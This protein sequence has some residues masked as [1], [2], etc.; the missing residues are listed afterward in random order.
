MTEPTRQELLAE[1]YKRGILPDDM[2]SN[3]EEAMRRGLVPGGD[4]KF[5]VGGVNTPSLNDM[6]DMRNVAQDRQ[7]THFER[8]LADRGSKRRKHLESDPEN[9]G[10]SSPKSDAELGATQYGKAEGFFF[11]LGDEVTGLINPERGEELSKLKRYARENYPSGFS[12]GEVHGLGVN[13]LATAPVAGVKMAQIPQA[14]R[15]GNTGRAIVGGSAGAAGF[16]AAYQ[17]TTGEGSFAE[18]VGDID[19][20]QTR[21]V[22]LI[23][24]AGGGV[25]ATLPKIASAANSVKDSLKGSVSGQALDMARV[26]SVDAPASSFEALRGLLK[27][28]GVPLPD[29]DRGIAEIHQGLQAGMDPLSRSSIFAVELQKRFPTARQQIKDAFQQL[30]TAPPNQGNT[31]QILQDALDAQSDSQVTY[32]D[33]VFQQRLGATSV[34]DEQAAL[35]IERGAIGE[36][37]DRVNNF[38][39]TDGRGKGIQK[40]MQAWL[41]EFADDREVMGHMRAAAREL[42]FKGNSEVADA[43]AKNPGALFQKFGETSGATLRSTR[44]GSPVLDQARRETENLVDEM[45]RYG[46]DDS[47]KF[48]SRAAGDVGPYKEQ[49]AKFRENYSQE[50]AIQTARGRF[51]AAKDPVKADE[52]VNWYNTLP[53]GEQRLVRTVIRQDME[54]M[55]RG[56]NIDD[57]GAYMTPL[58]KRGIHDVLARVLGKD[59][60]DISRAIQNVAEEQP[61]LAE[62]D[63]RKGLQARVVR[64][65]AADRAR[66]LYTNNPLA[67]LADS[68]PKVT[69]AGDIALMTGAVMTG[70]PPIP[71]ATLARQALKVLRPRKETREG[72]A[73]ILAMRPGSGPAPAAPVPTHPVP[74]PTGAPVLPAPVSAAP[75]ATSAPQPHVTFSPSPLIRP[76][77]Q[78]LP[79]AMQQQLTQKRTALLDA[80]EQ[81]LPPQRQ[82]EI[83][84]RRENWHKQPS[85]PAVRQNAAPGYDLPDPAGPLKTA[86]TLGFVAS[87]IW[88]GAALFAYSNMRQQE[89]TATGSFR[90]ALQALERVSKR[91]PTPSAPSIK[92]DLPQ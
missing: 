23:G 43:I 24:G 69:Q 84:E 57:T 92:P 16:D 13:A 75:A 78:A 81:S 6:V 34:A 10:W 61:H 91:Q 42:G 29:I 41:G 11:G 63:P 2:R 68:L 87:P 82:A 55:L 71:Y 37:R 17:T 86:A 36:I 22:G 47:G 73:Q 70:Q 83:V 44:G 8:M 7:D 52:F 46:R 39:F 45:S 32:L 14:I 48:V 38:A 3:Y 15:I 26:S 54:K 27:R 65:A 33:D 50:E 19:L 79:P 21:N 80:D 9:I 62:I 89:G 18:R 12:K 51:A 5:S 56:G 90:T 77:E 31:S 60:E 30:A 59:G 35:A 66:N 28:A 4:Q 1:A 88:G 20:E 74:A 64:G 76:Q 58:R 53:D 25:L 85:S 72:L 67:R 49:Q 40:Q